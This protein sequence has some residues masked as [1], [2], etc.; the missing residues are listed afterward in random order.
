MSEADV[1]ALRAAY[2]AVR[3]GGWEFAF[4]YAHPDFELV[5]ADRVTS[6]GTYRG[7]DAARAFFEDLTEPFDEFDAEPLEFFQRGDRV[8]VLLQVRARPRG[9]TAVLENRIGHVWTLRDGKVARLQIFP[10]REEALEAIGLRPDAVGEP[11]A[12]PPGALDR[13]P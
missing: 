5:T 3:R 7:V 12:P 1:E 4:Q 9:S 10:V 8:A 6:P 2:E 13:R 11:P